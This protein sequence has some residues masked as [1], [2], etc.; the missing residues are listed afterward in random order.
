M[1]AKAYN[2]TLVDFMLHSSNSKVVEL[3]TTQVIDSQYPTST[4]MMY[5]CK[6]NPVT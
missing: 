3:K 6:D 2:V 4:Y 5:A 1:F